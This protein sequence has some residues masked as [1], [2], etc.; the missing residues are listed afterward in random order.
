MGTGIYPIGN[1]RV[2]IGTTVPQ[3]NL[4]L[5]TTGT[6]STDLYV[7]NTTFLAGF[8]TTKDLQVGGALT[9]TTYSLD[10]STSN[11]VAGIVTCANIVV[12]GALSTSSG[13][14]GLGT[15]S[16]RAKLDIEGSTKFKTY[17]EYVGVVTSVGN[18]VS[19]DLSVAQSFTLTVAEAVSQ[20][21]LLNPPTGSTAFTV[22]ILQDSTG[23]SVGIDTFKNASS[24]EIAVYWPGGTVPTVTVTA[25]KTDIY[26][27]MTF[28]GGS[29]LYGVV[30]GQNF[31]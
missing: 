4:D 11:I 14:V 30:G 15:D 1:L 21:T 24:G 6:G 7:R 16:P 17:S 27:F 2:G 20:F 18:N 31:A 25:E 9:A 12:G 26:S 29:S 3:Y 23:Y 22:K 10:S 13:E 28:D 8:T 5:G 19:L